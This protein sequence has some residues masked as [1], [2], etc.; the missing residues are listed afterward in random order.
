MFNLRLVPLRILD[1]MRKLGIFAL[2]ASWLLIASLVPAGTG[3]AAGEP[4]DGFPKWDERVLHEWTNRARSD[5][6]FEMNNCPVGDCAEAACYSPVAPL[7]WTLA[8]SR[9]ARFHS[10]QLSIEG[11]SLQ[12]DSPCTLVSNIDA[13]YPD[14]CDGSA[15]C[16]CQE[17]YSTCGSAGTTW[18]Q[19]L[20]LFGVGTGWRGEN[21]AGGAT[22]PNTV[23]YWWLFEATSNPS[24][25]WTLENGHRHNILN[26]NFGSY[27]A[28]V[29]GIIW[30]TDFGPVIAADRIPSGS[31]YPRQAASVD[32]W[33]NWFDA[34]G[35]NEALANVEGTCIPMSLE[36]GTQTNG[37]W[38]ATATGVGSG[39]HRY[40][41]EFRDSSGVP[42]SYPTTGSLGIGPA[43][44]CADWDP[45][46][47]VSC[48]SAPPI[49]ALSPWGIA[50][51]GLSMLLTV[52]WVARSRSWS[53]E[54]A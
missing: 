45:A 38:M 40:Y 44:S 50:A 36:R 3:F 1:F 9:S 21:I 39:C 11:C 42:V 41:F 24:C 34:A 5:P 18:S 22:D 46:R 10:D 31:H 29:G 14:S 51:A 16:A 37:A 35:P 17:G 53:G 13:L 33:A 12:H 54:P 52:F 4:I 32:L 28:G 19:R 27:G 47:P 30:T 8:L 7:A 25:S 26:S 43:G 23:F 20:A 48:A 2:A 15:S 6:Q 49:P